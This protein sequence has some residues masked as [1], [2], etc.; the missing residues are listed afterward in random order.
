MAEPV[1]SIVEFTNKRFSLRESIIATVAYF[2]L[3]E[4]G[5][6][7]LEIWK[8]LL[9]PKGSISLKEV[10]D[11]V[12]Q[13]EEIE[14]VNGVYVLKGHT[15]LAEMR[16]SNTAIAK[17][18]YL[19]AKRVTALFARLPFVRMVA[20]VNTL[21]LGY[22]RDGS[23]IDFFIV[24]KA[25]TLAI[26]RLLCTGFLTIAGKRPSRGRERDAVC[27]SFFVGADALNLWPLSLPVKDGVP[28]VYLAQW[29]SHCTVL[30]DE[31]IYDDYVR[32]NEWIRKIIPNAVPNG[33]HFVRSVRLGRISH[34]IK[35][36][37][38]QSMIPFLGILERLSF[39]FQHRILPVTLR[40]LLNKD[41]RVVMTQRVMKFHSTRDRRAEI[42]E[43]WLSRV[44]QST[45]EI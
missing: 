3:F 38:E 39:W 16:R 29:M 4:Y 28:D 45:K 41:T 2:D 40:E 11:C 25:G 37:I 24:S 23:D 8:Y 34:T 17:R 43:Q 18:K 44:R 36:M 12:A 13:I 9:F 22:A 31:G 35:K 1:S 7:T 6:T 27:L 19:R 30:Y 14:E 20:I 21:G 42:R 33:G 15:M 32:Q 5:L 10:S 26:V